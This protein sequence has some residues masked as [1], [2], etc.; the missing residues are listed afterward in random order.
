M[1][2]VCAIFSYYLRHRGEVESYLAE[3]LREGAEIQA[4]IEAK[5]PMPEG[6]RAKLLA[7]LDT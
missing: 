6:L 2:D 3:Q 7:R 5:Y 1:A 4:R